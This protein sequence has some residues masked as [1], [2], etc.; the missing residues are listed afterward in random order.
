MRLPRQERT[1]YEPEAPARELRGGPA[2]DSRAL[3]AGLLTVFLAGVIRTR[4]IL[5]GGC[6]NSE[7]SRGSGFSL[8]DAAPPCS[9]IAD[10]RGSRQ[11]TEC[12]LEPIRGRP[13]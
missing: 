10:R 3:R 2:T 7:P 11:E 9:I 13:R 4:S 8:W 5:S 12:R 6:R 1:S